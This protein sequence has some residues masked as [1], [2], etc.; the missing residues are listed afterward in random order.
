[1]SDIV[2]NDL[3]KE[4][5]ASTTAFGQYTAIPSVAKNNLQQIRSFAV[6]RRDW[7][8][9]Y[10]GGEID[11][12]EEE[13]IPCTG[14][15]KETFAMYFDETSDSTQRVPVSFTPSNTTDKPVWKSNNEDVVRVS[16]GYATAVGIGNTTI[17]I[18]CGDQTA[19]MYVYVSYIHEDVDVNE[20]VYQL[21][22]VTTFSGSNYIDTG[23]SVL[24][25]DTPFTVFVDWTDTNECAF[26]D[27]THVIVHCMNEYSPYPGIVMQYG[28]SGITSA[29]RQG[30]ANITTSSNN[31]AI[32]N[33]DIENVKT[34]FR[35][36]ENG[37][38]TVAN[39]Y[40][41]NGQ[42]YKTEKTMEYVAV[43]EALRLGCYRSNTG[44]PGRYAKGILNDCKIYN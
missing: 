18:T 28:P 38:V 22:A 20:I 27:A 39:V 25:E 11:V 40:N 36:D 10:F 32:A 44:A 30:S 35:K 16:Q 37:L 9:E 21:P 24:A 5:Y 31:A 26:S 33:A 2:S 4:D 7:T 17:S 13:R 41:E 15:S 12:P 43:G 42:I 8:D 29:Y 19:T 3:I 23:I 1:M 14:I 34:V 6:N